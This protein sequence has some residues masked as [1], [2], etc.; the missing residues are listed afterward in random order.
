MADMTIVNGIYKPTYNW[1][2]PSCIPTMKISNQVI[3][4]EW[5]K[6]GQW[7][8]KNPNSSASRDW[9]WAGT[10]VWRLCVWRL[11]YFF[12]GQS[13]FLGARF[14]GKP[15]LGHVRLPGFNFTTNRKRE[16]RSSAARA[17]RARSAARAFPTCRGWVKGTIFQEILRE[18]PYNP[19]P[20]VN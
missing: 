2:A 7:T 10:C 6:M 12:W 3:A 9:T 13:I 17:W 8:M 4:P 19:I 11:C 16:K 14:S 20:Q 5:S 18:I 15:I 1:G